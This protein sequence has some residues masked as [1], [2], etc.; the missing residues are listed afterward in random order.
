MLFARRYFTD[1][2]KNHYMCVVNSVA[3]IAF[4]FVQQHVL[5]LK[6]KKLEGRESKTTV[7]TTTSV[8]SLLTLAGGYN[9]ILL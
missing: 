9:N 3:V 5:S 8:L 4:Q 1:E 6:K 2:D 7:K